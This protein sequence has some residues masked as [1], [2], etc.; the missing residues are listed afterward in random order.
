MSWAQIADC[1]DESVTVI[2]EDLDYAGGWVEGVLGE[3]GITASEVPP[4]QPKLLA[5]QVQMALAMACY[6]SA[7]GQDSPLLDKGDRYTKQAERL[8]HAINRTALGLPAAN[9]GAR[10]GVGSV[11]IGRG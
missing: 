10:A 1:R 2:Q 4:P 9:G 7:A 3:R 8:A 5:V 6:R 11:E